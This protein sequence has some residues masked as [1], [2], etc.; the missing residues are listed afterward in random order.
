M[1]LGIVIDSATPAFPPAA[2]NL[3]IAQPNQ[4][5][6]QR[7]NAFGYPG[8]YNDDI[9]RTWVGI[10]SQIAG[11]GHLGENGIHDNRNDEKDFARIT[12]L[13]KLGV[14]NIPPLVGRAAII[15]MAAHFGKDALAA[16]DPFGEADIEAAAEAQGVAMGEGDIVLFHTGWNARKRSDGLG[17]GR[18]GDR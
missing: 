4:Q 10:G 7:L 13:T 8:V 5:G 14:H 15:D 16:G 17:L 18:A 3:Q 12:E 2:L 11:L 6:A 1:P 9:T